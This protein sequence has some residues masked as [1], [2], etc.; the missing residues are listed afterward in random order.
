MAELARLLVI[1]EIVQILLRGVASIPG[2]PHLSRFRVA[3]RVPTAGRT[4]RGVRRTRRG[5][6]CARV[7]ESGY[8]MLLS[9]SLQEYRLP[10]GSLLS[11]VLRL[12]R[13]VDGESVAEDQVQTHTVTPK[14]GRAR[15]GA[16]TRK[17]TLCQAPAVWNKKRNRP[18]NGRCRMHGGLSTGPRTMDGRRRALAN[19]RQ[20]RGERG[21][22]A[23]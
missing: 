22:P 7:I 23:P 3:C 14:R 20:Y 21:V 2:A 15:C 13:V 17:G 18:V 6:T 4:G 9:T 12:V 5:K 16:R 11:D 8:R 1:R 10:M 19:L